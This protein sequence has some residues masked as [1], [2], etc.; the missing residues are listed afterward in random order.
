MKAKTDPLQTILAAREQR[1]LLRRQFE[2]KGLHTVSLSLN[3]PGFPKSNSVVHSFFR[4]CLNELGYF[5]KAHLIEI[6]DSDAIVITDDAGDFYIAPC[7]TS[8]LSVPEIKQICENFEEGHPLGRFTDVDLN[9]A[10]GNAISSGKE[11]CC[12]FCHKKPAIECRRLNTHNHAQLRAFMFAGMAGYCR[13][14]RES[15]IGKFLSSLALSAVLDEISLSPKPGLVDKFSNG[16]HS[17]MNYR[18]FLASSASIS[19]WFEELVQAGLCFRGNDLSEALPVIRTIGLRMEKAMYDSTEK[20][21]TQKGVIFLLGLSLFACGKLY[22]QSDQFDTALF[23]NIIRAICKDIVKKEL[24]ALNRPAMSHGEEIFLQYGFCGARGEAESGFNTVFEY[25][26][27]LLSSA[28][29]HDDEV[30]IK[31]FLAMAANNDDTNI[32]Y[33]QGPDVSIKFKELC[34]IALVNFNEVNYSHVTDFCK[35]ENISPGGSADLLA[36]TTFIWSV[37]KADPG[38]DIIPLTDAK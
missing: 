24:G 29:V 33:R 12:F 31:C 13:Q 18:S 17:D 10:Q 22:S 11:K 7:S 5:L 28:S 34:R 20:I 25:G 32:L 27:P 1:A 37:M 16:S 38:K 36:V 15:A 14:Q 21:N 19:C 8:Y 2:Q 26:L 9:D 23:R 6:A 35:S 4:L 3:V 30:L